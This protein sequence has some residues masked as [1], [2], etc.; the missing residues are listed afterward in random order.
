MKGWW[1]YLLEC[2]DFSLYCGVSKDVNKRVRAHNAGK[3]AKYTRGRRPVIAIA[4]IGGM[5]EGEARSLEHS[6]KKQ[7]RAKKIERLLEG[8]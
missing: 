1:V 4:K 8:L 2:S 5:T 7:P 3:G 6:V